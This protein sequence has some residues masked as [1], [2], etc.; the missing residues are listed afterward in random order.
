MADAP[1]QTTSS[2]MDTAEMPDY[3]R[4]SEDVRADVCVVGAGIAGLTTAY[5]L[6]KEGVSV[7]VLEAGTVGSGQT[8]RTTAHLSNA[9]DDRYFELERLLGQHRTHLAAQSH[10]AAIDRI[11]TIV[12]EEGIECD[13]ERVDGY[14]FVPEDESDITLER[15]IQAAH[16]VGLLDVQWVEQAP[17]EKF[18]TGRCLR[19][20][21]QGQFHPLKY[22]AG[23]AKVFT[24]RGGQIFTHTHVRRINGGSPTRVQTSHGPVVIA[25]ATIVA[26][27]SP[28]I[29]RIGVITKQEPYRTFVIAAKVA[30][31]KITKALYWDTLDPYHYVRIQKGDPE[32]GEEPY[33]LLVVGGEDYKTGQEDDGDDRFVLLE[34]WMRDHFPAAQKVVYQW[35]GQVQE[36]L[37]G[38]GYIGRDLG[39]SRNVYIATGDSGQGMT[40]G[41][42]AGMVLTDLLLGRRNPW[43]ALYEPSR[44]PPG[45]AP[46]FAG[47]GLNVALQY[48]DWLDSGDV[49]S[50]AEVVAGTG[51]VVRRGLRKVAVYRDEDNQLH[52]CSAVCPH[53]GCIVAWNSTENTWDCPCH[54]SHFDPY[55]RVLTGPAIKNLD[56]VD[57]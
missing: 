4:L 19:F 36:T 33:D 24:E 47:A 28:V 20:P 27:N 49:D 45:V 12:R 13:F 42:I 10:T 44:F 56:R 25:K 40:H 35:S 21:A 18:D 1:E 26:T 38:L 37:D 6:A 53:L 43:A 3:S 32:E 17:L 39:G 46:D 15:E 2:W 34:S 5:L 50:Y 7:V 57:D 31:D 54:G 9:L 8:G 29:D 11:E 16:R 22:L 23:L 30:P 52:R 55:G 41:T 48:T 14:L 51:A